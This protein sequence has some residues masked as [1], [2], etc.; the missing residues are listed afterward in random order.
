MLHM[1]IEFFINKT[2]LTIWALQ[3][4]PIDHENIP[5]KNEYLQMDLKLPLLAMIAH[6]AVQSS[7]WT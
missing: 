5:A 7:A 3:A 1:V 4:F 2:K 6:S